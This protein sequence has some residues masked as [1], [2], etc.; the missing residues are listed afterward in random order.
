MNI[1]SNSMGKYPNYS[2][3]MIFGII[4]ELKSV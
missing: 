2:G 1:R 3:M 4:C